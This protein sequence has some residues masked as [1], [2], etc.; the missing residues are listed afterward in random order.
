MHSTLLAHGRIE[1]PYYSTNDQACLWIERKTWVYRTVFDRPYAAETAGLLLEFDGLDTLAE[2]F[3]NGETVAVSDNMF[4]PVAAELAGKLKER[5]N[6]LVVRFDPVVE[7]AARQDI[8]RFWSKVN[9]E[10][11]WL[12][13][14][15]CNFSWDWSPRVVTAG[16]WK[17]A[18]LKVVPA[19]RL[20]HLNF[21]TLSIG[22]DSAEVEV[23]AEVR[24]RDAS[25]RLTAEVVLRGRGREIRHETEVM[26]G[27]IGLRFTVERPSLWWTFD[28]GGALPLRVDR[29]SIGGRRARRRVVRGGR[30]PDDR[31][32]SALGERKSPLHVRPERQANLRQRRE[33]DSGPQLHRRHPGRTLRRSY[34]ALPGS[35]YEH[36]ARMGRR[37][38]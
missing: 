30:H 6:V 21:K 12:R 10:R 37:R 22:P 9:Y 14:C 32:Q 8:S 11:I 17:E 31:G 25:A 15:A 18:R 33:L 23:G 27:A 2:V 28:H 3:L 29:Q 19:A 36:A 24:H 5:D 7:Y 38:L 35:Q 20:E 1:D 16:I 4:V 26:D 34:R 13:K